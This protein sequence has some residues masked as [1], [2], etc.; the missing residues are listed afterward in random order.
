MLS[1]PVRFESLGPGALQTTENHVHRTEI[2]VAPD[3]GRDQIQTSGERHAF[4]QI[5]DPA[6]I[7]ERDARPTDVVECVRTDVVEPEP[8]R[9]LQALTTHLTRAVVAIG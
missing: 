8:L 5:L 6:R 4:L 3:H 9:H 1:K 7:T 2:V